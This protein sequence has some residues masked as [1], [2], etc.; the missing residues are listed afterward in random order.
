MMAVPGAR[1]LEVTRGTGS[2]GQTRSCLD[3]ARR[4]VSDAIALAKDQEIPPEVRVRV[5]PGLFRRCE[6]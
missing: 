1:I 2:A 6:H 5:L 3:P 4:Y